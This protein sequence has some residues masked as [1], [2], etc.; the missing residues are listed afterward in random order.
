VRSFQ[1]EAH[2]LTL[3]DG[4]HLLIQIE[5]KRLLYWAGSRDSLDKLHRRACNWLTEAA[6]AAD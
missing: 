2:L 1:R 6:S 5:H 4:E 3:D